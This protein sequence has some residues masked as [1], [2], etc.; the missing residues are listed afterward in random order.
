MA[1]AGNTKTFTLEGLSDLLDGLND[2]PKATS[3]NV[4]KRALLKAAQPIAD[5]AQSLA[6]IRKGTL[7]RKIGVGTKLAPS[8]RGPKESKYEVYVGSES[9]VQAITSEFGTIHERPRPFMRPAWDSNKEGAFETIKTELGNEIAKALQRIA[10]K[11][12]RL[13]AAS[14][15]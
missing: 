13:L 14:G 5:E 4:I 10:R 6:P 8:Q 1:L 15:K 7:R 2:L 11:T 12:A 3:A 9:L